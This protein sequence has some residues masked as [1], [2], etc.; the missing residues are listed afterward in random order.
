MTQKNFAQWLF[1]KNSTQADKLAVVDNDRGLTYRELELQAKRFAQVLV[2]SGLRPQQRI[3]ICL[4]DCVEWPIFF[5]AC[6]TAGLNPVLVSTDLPIKNLQRIMSLCDCAAMITKQHQ[7]HGV[8]NFTKTDAW[9]SGSE[10]QDFYQYHSDEPCFWLL[11]S[12]TT[13]EPKCIVHPHAN[14]HRLLELV[15]GPAYGID[16]NS[17]VLST[18]KLSFTYGFNNGVTFALGQG[19]TTYLI[20]GVP[21]P[22]L[23][24][25]KIQQHHITHF[26]TVPTVIASMLRHGADKKLH[27]S[28]QLMV[29][30]GEPLPENVRVEFEQQHDLTIYN[31]IGM[32][33]TTQTYCAQTKINYEANT[34]GQALPGVELQVRDDDGSVVPVGKI[35]ELFVKSPCQALMYWKDSNKSKST[36][37]G[38]WVRTG[39]KVIQTAQ[40]NL[41]YVS[42]ADDLIKING[43]YVS[44]IEVESAICQMP[45]IIECA[46]VIGHDNHMPEIHAFVI[47][48]GD[49]TDSHIKMH[50]QSQLERHKIPKRI[51]FIDSLPK[52]VTFKKQRSK[53]R[54]LV[55]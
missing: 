54:E 4:E 12:G 36:F 50:L 20:N 34:V 16:Q 40:G 14:L 13:G 53:L 1:E 39:D 26:F 33:E 31:C 52:T 9:T 44:P 32:S 30:S 23:I 22:S 27:D 5:L 41:I 8:R 6:L 2:Q 25:D 18:A 35:G 3:I 10:I 24:F 49:I 11:S 17:R 46:V 55:C 15:A 45:G 19:A 37:L 7:D 48:E 21:A 43:M 28:V 47:R 38:E 51:H 42:R 29:S